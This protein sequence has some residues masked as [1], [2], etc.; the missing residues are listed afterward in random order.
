MQDIMPG[1]KPTRVPV[2]VCM[3]THLC[4]SPELQNTGR[5]FFF[6]LALPL[7]LPSGFFFFPG[8]FFITVWVGWVQENS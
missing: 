5:N 3:S 1:V 8:V 7:P 4:T 2:C 6:F